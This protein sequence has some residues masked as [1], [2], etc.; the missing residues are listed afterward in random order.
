MRAAPAVVSLSVHVGFVAVALWATSAPAVPAARRPV[1]IALPPAPVAPRPPVVAGPADPALP[2]PS[3]PLLPDLPPIAVDSLLP[4]TPAGPVAPL[5]GRPERPVG[6]SG[7]GPAGPIDA[8]FVQDPPVLLASPVP[9]YPDLLRQAGIEGQ[10]V[11]DAV[12]DTTGRVESGSIAV[13][14][15]TNPQFVEPARRT[16]AG[17]LFRPGRMNG[18]AV[19]VRIRLPVVFGLRRGV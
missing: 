9:A 13:V 4:R 17:A 14:L 8:A 5:A 11:L 16:L 7:A 1:M 18:R 3:V 10:V 2:D 6:I 12:V 19:R 15:A